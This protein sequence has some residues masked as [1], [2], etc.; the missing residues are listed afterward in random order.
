MFDLI[1]A[2][3]LAQSTPAPQSSA[4]PDAMSEPTSVATGTTPAPTGIPAFRSF[5]AGPRHIPTELP[6]LA[7]G[8]VL[9][10]NS[11]STNTAG[12]SIVIHPDYTADVADGR[13]GTIKKTVGAPQAKWLFDRLKA[14]M[15]FEQLGGGHCM[16]SASFGSY[17]TIAYN[18]ERTPDLQCP[19][20][21]ETRELNRTVGVIVEQLGISTRRVPGMMRL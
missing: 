3:L 8:D 6:T 14:D 15:P 11:G 2:A 12:Y 21:P 10:R 17:T 20:G 7:P 13:G 19:G 4:T 16:K 9:I 18:G 5:P 1:L